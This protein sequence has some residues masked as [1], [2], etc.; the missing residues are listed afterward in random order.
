MA[1]LACLVLYCFLDC[2]F[3]KQA[4]YGQATRRLFV[5]IYLRTASQCSLRIRLA[6][7]SIANKRTVEFGVFI[8]P[9][10]SSIGFL[11][12]SLDP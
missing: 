12:K 8:Q 9:D 4:D 1:C 7:A 3:I 2:F 11:F 6:A 5:C 10:F